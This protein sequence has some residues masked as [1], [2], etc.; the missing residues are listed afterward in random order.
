MN[1]S[2]VV[3]KALLKVI[4]LYAN[5]V[6]MDAISLLINKLIRV[7]QLEKNNLYWNENDYINIFR[8]RTV[9]DFFILYIM[10]GIILSLIEIIYFIIYLLGYINI[11]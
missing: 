1:L 8:P 6:L 11:K 9:N 4:F 10:I 7:L 2:L 5:G 3:L